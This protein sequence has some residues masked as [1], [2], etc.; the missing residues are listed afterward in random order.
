MHRSATADSPKISRRDFLLGLGAALGT[1]TL[2]GHENRKTSNF[3][4]Q[5]CLCAVETIEEARGTI[6]ASV[7]RCIDECET[8]DGFALLAQC[9]N[10]QGRIDGAFMASLD[11][12][13]SAT[14]ASGMR[15]V[16]KALA[17]FPELGPEV[18]SIAEENLRQRSLLDPKRAALFFIN[19]KEKL[20]ALE[21]PEFVQETSTHY[22][23]IVE[24]KRME[25]LALLTNTH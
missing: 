7:H 9:W 12:K 17:K 24:P 22:I 1:I 21:V 19:Q 14:V 11:Q 2:S 3:H 4:T 18:L 20:A 13:C 23:R 8:A 16:A 5:E 25:T 15:T 10:V 6:R